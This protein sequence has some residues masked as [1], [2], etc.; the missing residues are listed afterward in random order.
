MIYLPS[1]I[2]KISQ[3]H[4]FV[5]MLTKKAEPMT[6][7]MPDTDEEE[8][9]TQEEEVTGPQKYQTAIGIVSVLEGPEGNMDM[10]EILYCAAERYKI[11]TELHGGYSEVIN[12]MNQALA[13]L[14]D[15]SNEAIEETEDEDRIDELFDQAKDAIDAME[16][17]LQLQN[18][19]IPIKERTPDEIVHQHLLTISENF[20]GT[21]AKEMMQQEVKYETRRGATEEGGDKGEGQ[22]GH[23]TGHEKQNISDPYIRYK[24]EAEEYQKKLDEIA[25]TPANQKLR[26]SITKLID[27]N[28]ALHD[29]ANKTA[30]L[31][32]DLKV[33]PDDEDLK[34]EYH[35][36]MELLTELRKQK[37]FATLILKN[38]V[39]SK[40]KAHLEAQIALT[41][42]PKEKEWLQHKLALEDLIISD[43]YNK[44]DEIKA[45][46]HLID[47]TGGM[48]S[49]L[50]DPRK[51]KEFHSQA[52]PPEQLKKLI[53]A[54]DAGAG[55]KLTPYQY[56]RQRHLKRTQ[57]LGLP[58]PE[59]RES[60]RGGWSKKE[61]HD[62]LA[63]DLEDP[64]YFRQRSG[65][66][67]SER[68]NTAKA[69]CGYYLWRDYKNKGG[70]R[71]EAEG[72]ARVEAEGGH[73]ELRVYVDAV[74]K[75]ILKGNESEK[76]ASIAKLREEAK[77]YVFKKRTAMESYETM[78]RLFPFV[79]LIQ[80]KIDT[81]ASWQAAD[82]SWNIDDTKKDV[83][84]DTATYIL[85]FA[86]AYML[87]Y[88][89]RETNFDSLVSS[90]MEAEIYIE[91]RLLGEKYEKTK[92]EVKPEEKTETKSS[93][94]NSEKLIQELFS[95]IEQETATQQTVEPM[96]EE[97]PLAQQLRVED[98]I[99]QKQT[100]VET[101][102]RPVLLVTRLPNGQ[103]EMERASLE[104]A[105]I[106]GAEYIKTKDNGEQIWEI[107][108]EEEAEEPTPLKKMIR[109]M[110][111]IDYLKKIAERTKEERREEDRI[112]TINKA[113]E[114]G[115]ISAVPER[116]ST[117]GGGL[118]GTRLSKT[119]QDIAAFSGLIALLGQKLQTA[120]VTA[121]EKF[122]KERAHGDPKYKPYIDAITTSVSKKDTKEYHS[123]MRAL[124]FA[125]GEDK[126][127]ELK[128]LKASYRLYPFFVK[129]KNDLKKL[130]DTWSKD[131]GSWDINDKSVAE[132]LSVIKECYRLM[133]IYHEHY[134]DDGKIQLYYSK[135]IQVLFI[136][137]ERLTE[138]IEI[139][140]KDIK[141]V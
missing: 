125:L 23:T 89:Y 126:Q 32:D 18:K 78:L 28:I 90:L 120:I 114:R 55:A 94:E 7:V 33:V 11:A 52:L 96:I 70:A 22:V 102:T 130:E 47:A 3:F 63:K 93:K 109:R 87:Q 82:G 119:N 58:I 17:D 41:R 56:D 38:F 27:S 36:N 29:Q 98:L 138:I 19:T 54:I 76:Y 97:K 14:I 25:N 59:S 35:T 50:I 92:E 1:L 30:K 43:Y 20:L 12:A 118:K 49:S 21:G 101:P 79:K 8:E 112:R 2:N 133:A 65:T 123:A 103:M 107:R 71:V 66:K 74:S 95:Q 13:Q 44:K 139:W 136:I 42:D 100:R 84:R 24:E 67:L 51:P 134:L 57:T 131:D 68:I 60:K 110:S 83:L 10:A 16:E 113:I 91:D 85:R 128:I 105:Q 80:D 121:K 61:K 106:R 141:N 77:K 81:I 104:D 69:G 9:T 135:V 62:L 45:R 86:N 73:P 124:E 48:F 6:Y 46:Q 116:A 140:K 37:R 122:T 99:P 132:I 127:E 129:I 5:S 31:R 111:R 40:K 34:Q 26:A 88:K 53:D 4:D 137:T 39:H 108:L 64:N 75:A 15:A 115:Q 117:K 72:G